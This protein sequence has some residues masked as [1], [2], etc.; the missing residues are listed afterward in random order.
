MT[1]RI[2]V[3]LALVVFLTTAYALPGAR[4]AGALVI[5]SMMIVALAGYGH[6]VIELR[7]REAAQRSRKEV[8][9]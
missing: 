9:A 5:G 8:S 7:D 6:E 2:V 4:A 1:A 3:T